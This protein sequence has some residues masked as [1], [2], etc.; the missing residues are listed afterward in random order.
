MAIYGGFGLLL[1]ISFLTAAITFALGAIRAARSLHN[2]LLGN[3]LRLPM[4]FFDTTPLGRIVNRFSRD[5]DM[6]DSYIPAMMFSWCNMLFS[7]AGTLVIISYATP[8]FAAVAVPLVIFYYLIQKFYIKTSR[9]LKRIESVTRSPIY[10]HF[11]ESVSGQ[12]VIRAYREQDRFEK[13]SE[14][15]VDKNLSVL[16]LTNIADCWLGVRLENIGA[17]IVLFACLF[18][19]LARYDIQ[20]AMVGLSISYAIQISAVLSYFVMI[21]TE[22]RKFLKN[23][24]KLI[25][26]TSIP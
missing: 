8:W 24:K 3:I 4:A 22:V 9:Q 26:S 7:V 14:M 10:S 16:Y 17:F 19:I 15:K 6:I 1:G 12:S 5:T 25:L 23:P 21:A 13:E 2:R 11:G 20:E 18:A